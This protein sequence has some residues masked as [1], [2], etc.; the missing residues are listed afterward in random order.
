MENR[1][2]L[3]IFKSLPIIITAI[4][5]INALAIK[6]QTSLTIQGQSPYIWDI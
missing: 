2:K 6:A 4:L 5:P 1:K 3:S